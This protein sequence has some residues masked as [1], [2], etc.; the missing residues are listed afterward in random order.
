MRKI[1]FKLKKHL[2]NILMTLLL[3]GFAVAAVML[4]PR[5]TLTMAL[6]ISWLD[7]NQ[8]IKYKQSSLF[9]LQ[10][11]VQSRGI[12]MNFVSTGDEKVARSN[13]EFI[14]D[15]PD[16]DLVLQLNTGAELPK[17]ISS[18][19][20][21]LGSVT[22]APIFFFTKTRAGK[23]ITK[24]R[25]LKGKK[26]IF[27]S[28]PEGNEKPVF[29][30]GGAKPSNF[31]SDHILEKIFS[32]AGVTAENSTLINTWPEGVRYEEDWDVHIT[33]GTPSLTN[34]SKAMREALDAGKVEFLQLE[35]VDAIA[36]RIPVLKVKSL[37]AS[38]VNMTQGVPATEIRYLT[39]TASLVVPKKLD[40]SLVLVLAEGAQKIYSAQTLTT[41]KDELPTFSRTEFLE[42]SPIAAEFYERGSQFLNNFLIE[43]MSATFAIYLAKMAFIFIPLLSVL[44]PVLHFSPRIYNF[45]IRHKTTHWYAELQFIEDHY[46]ECTS[47]ERSAMVRRL[48]EIDNILRKTKLPFFHTHYV[49][50]IFRTR[51]H[52]DFVRK[53]VTEINQSQ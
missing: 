8:Q 46:L 39:Y 17:E 38:S 29:T 52:L 27:Y 35:D 24:L 45:Y 49:Q 4:Y 23:K 22:V 15:H 31:S 1:A 5:T 3:L 10:E 2:P 33:F 20:R 14:T 53:K 34:K 12:E 36:K 19:F 43:H 28:T 40:S 16:V 11:H 51:R 13:L 26:I 44:V 9:K 50:E 6:P 48:D 7:E 37:P 32:L 47:Q 42:P 21:S 25:D 30:P 18:R 41:D